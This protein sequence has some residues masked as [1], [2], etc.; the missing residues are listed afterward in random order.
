MKLPYQNEMYELRKWIDTTNANMSMQ[1]SV[2][3]TP[4]EVNAVRYWIGVVCKNIQGEYP[5]YASILPQ[6]AKI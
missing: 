6:I 1:F 2:M 5:F 3:H 4:Q